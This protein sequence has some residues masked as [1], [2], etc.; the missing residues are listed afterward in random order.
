MTSYAPFLLYFEPCALLSCITLPCRYWILFNLTCVAAEQK[1]GSRL[2][3]LFI[4][5]LMYQGIDIKKRMM[6]KEACK[7]MIF[8]KSDDKIAAS[9]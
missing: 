5:F 2:S 6:F 9:P 8:G 7:R 1:V 4:P 3:L